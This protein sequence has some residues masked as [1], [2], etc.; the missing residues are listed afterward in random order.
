MIRGTTP[1][2]ILNVK[3]VDLTDKTVFVTISQGSKKITM[4]N[5]DIGI[6]KVDD[7]SI[8]SIRLT[9]EQT[10]G[11][12]DGNAKIQVRFIDSENIAK[13]TEIASISIS[14][15]LLERVI[16]YNGNN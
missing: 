6:S 16:E 10:L 8:I 12:A 7:D 15:V 9:Q 2:Y 13:A 5:N 11:F 3:G 4:S 14:P 1:D